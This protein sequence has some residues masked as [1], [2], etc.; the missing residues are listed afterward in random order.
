MKLLLLTLL[1]AGATASSLSSFSKQI[2]DAKEFSGNIWAVLVAGSNG[3]YNYRHQADVCHAYQILKSHGVP[4]ERIVVMMYDDIA[5]NPSNP[6]PGKIINKPGGPNVYE[7]VPK[8]YVGDDVSAENFLKVLEGDQELKNAGNKVLESGEEDHVFIFYSDHGAVG[9][10]AMPTGTLY[11]KDFIK[12]LD[13]LHEG[14]K[15]RR[16]VVYI[17]ACESGSMFDGILD[18]EK[19]IYGV[20]ASGPDESSWAYYC[21]TGVCLGDEFSVKWMEDSDAVGDLNK[22]TLAQQFKHVKAAV[23]KS[24]VH[25]YGDLSFNESPVAEFQGAVPV[26]PKLESFSEQEHHRVVSYDVPIFQQEMKV[27]KTNSKLEKKKLD[28]MKKGR[29]FIDTVTKELAEELEQKHGF[30]GLHKAKHSLEKHDC[31]KSLVDAYNK[32]CFDV[33]KHSYALRQ[34]QLFVNT[35]ANLPNETEETVSPVVHTIEQFCKQHVEEHPFAAV[36]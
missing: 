11:A 32:H 5:H 18:R 36:L 23:K 2:E 8:D 26:D 12:T 29:D 4:D 15:Y 6:T 28:A 25:H 24:G 19:R 30:N 14:N 3:W 21:D 34:L 33:S 1:V 10:V 31:Y 20:T 35:C 27:L 16:M 9:L 17:E 22:E 7:G 13:K